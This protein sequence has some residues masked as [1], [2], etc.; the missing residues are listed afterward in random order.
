MIDVT[1]KRC[2][3]S[4]CNWRPSFNYQNETRGIYCMTH[5]IDEM[6]DVKHKRCKFPGCN[7]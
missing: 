6:I 3:F 2:Q 7:S 5:K 1:S 4:G